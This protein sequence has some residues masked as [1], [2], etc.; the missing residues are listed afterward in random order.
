MHASSSHSH[1]T[2]DDLSMG[3]PAN[4]EGMGHASLMLEGRS[5]GDGFQEW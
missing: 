4:A 3:A 5:I 1:A 2:D